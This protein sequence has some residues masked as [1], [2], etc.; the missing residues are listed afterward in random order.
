MRPQPGDLGAVTGLDG[1]L[2]TLR[3]GYGVTLKA[4]RLVVRRVAQRE[5]EAA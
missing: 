5:A 3:S 2:Y 4:G 1:S